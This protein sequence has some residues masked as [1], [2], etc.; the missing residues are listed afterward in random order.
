MLI[1]QAAVSL[2]NLLSHAAMLPVAGGAFAGV[3]F[4]FF[5]SPVRP[6]GV[7]ESESLMNFSSLGTLR[8]ICAKSHPEFLGADR[9]EFCRSC[10]CQILVPDPTLLDC[11]ISKEQARK[12]T[13]EMRDAAI[14]ASRL[15]LPSSITSIEELQQY[16][17]SDTKK[18]PRPVS[19]RQPPVEQT[20]VQ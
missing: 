10:G 7:R 13:R 8:C 2:Q 12:L 9:R 17:A 3:T 15:E 11:Q 4:A 19:L 20:Q 1:I 18:S 14:R 6:F 5:R 16:L